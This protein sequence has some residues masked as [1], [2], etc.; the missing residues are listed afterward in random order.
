[1]R[2]V[3][4]KRQH[5]SST[6]LRPHAQ[7]LPLPLCHTMRASCRWCHSRELNLHLCVLILT[8]ATHSLT[9]SLS[10]GTGT[11]WATDTCDGGKTVTLSLSLSLPPSLFCYCLSVFTSASSLL[12]FPLLSHLPCDRWPA[13]CLSLSLLSATHVC[14]SPSNTASID[15][16]PPLGPRSPFPPSCSLSPLSLRF[17]ACCEQYRHEHYGFHRSGRTKTG[18]SRNEP[19][20]AV[21]IPPSHNVAVDSPPTSAAART[22]CVFR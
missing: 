7:L 20:R 14:L 1:M 13:C 12:F 10:A 5:V 16:C 9:H 22:L 21:A 18:P 19:I 15:I 6:S 11:G 2:F 4:S 8:T 17:L 3:F